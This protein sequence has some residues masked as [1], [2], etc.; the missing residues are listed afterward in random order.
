MY[1]SMEDYD[2]AAIYYEKALQIYEDVGFDV[3]G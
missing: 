3:S 2:E 1:K